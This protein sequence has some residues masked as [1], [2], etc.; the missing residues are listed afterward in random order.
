MLGGASLPVVHGVTDLGVA[1]LCCIWNVERGRQ[2]AI[3][4]L[5]A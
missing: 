4:N 1:H 5:A 3:R 2:R